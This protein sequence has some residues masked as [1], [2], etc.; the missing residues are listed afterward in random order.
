MRDSSPLLAAIC[1]DPDDIVARLAYAD[2]LEERGEDEDRAALIRAQVALAGAD[3]DDPANWPAMEEEKALRKKLNPKLKDKLRAGRY[4]IYRNG[5]I[6]GLTLTVDEFL[7]AVPALFDR[8]P[9]RQVRFRGDYGVKDQLAELVKC[10]HLSRLRAIDVSRG[11]W[12]SGGAKRLAEC[13]YLD[14]IEELSLHWEPEAIEHLAASGMLGRLRM[15]TAGGIDDQRASLIGEAGNRLTALHIG[16]RLSDAGLSALAGSPRLDQLRELSLSSDTVGADGIAALVV[17]PSLERL[18]LGYAHIGPTQAQG[19]GAVSQPSRL[20]WLS[21]SEQATWLR[22]RTLEDAGATTLA[23]SHSLAG[24]RFLRAPR[25]GIG[26]KGAAA[27]ARLGELR[28]LSLV[29]NPIGDEGAAALARSPQMAGLRSLHLRDC[30]I[31][32]LGAKALAASRS[33]A[34]LARLDLKGNPIRAAGERAL[35]K[36]F[37][38]ALRRE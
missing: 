4:A 18:R 30:D 16:G 5:F 9:L 23:R 10:P 35:E 19:F 33:L 2:W 26:P 36:R 21:I 38:A 32:S 28:T 12:E 15:L 3:H 34:G 31:G 29:H 27:L 7:K 11:G 20:R 6:E 25:N 13:A 1:A 24:L 37:G 8:T 14:G 22:G 17:H